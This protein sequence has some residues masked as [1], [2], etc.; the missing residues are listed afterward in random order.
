MENP[1]LMN[2]AITNPNLEIKNYKRRQQ[3]LTK[4]SRI[5]F[6][7]NPKYAVDQNHFNDISTV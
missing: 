1:V 3:R 2:Y 5:Y 6:K 4:L 7:N